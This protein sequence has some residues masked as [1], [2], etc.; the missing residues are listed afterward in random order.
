MPNIAALELC[1][2]EL[3]TS[4]EELLQRRYALP[5][6]ERVQRIRAMYLWLIANPEATDSQFVQ[7]LQGRYNLSHVT[8]YADLAIIKSLLPNIAAAARD[9]HR[10][11]YNEMIL[12]TYQMA[13]KRKDTKTMERA[14]T[15][16]AKYNSI[17]LEEEQ[18]IPFEEIVVQPFTATSDPTVLGIKP[19]PNL[20]AKINAMIEK[21]RRETIDIEEISFEEADLEEG[22]LFPTKREERDPIGGLTTKQNPTAQREASASTTRHT[23]K[24]GG[25]R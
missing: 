13:K 19:I 11:R 23:S 9:F 7:E 14:A 25:T 1:R 24:R 16:Y 5:L 17:Q 18:Q 21:Y 3:F 22:E 2:R 15:S 8:A 10:W 12:S 6:I 4:K 20:Q